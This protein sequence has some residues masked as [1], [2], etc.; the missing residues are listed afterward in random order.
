[1]ATLIVN[2]VVKNSPIKGWGG[3]SKNV[4]KMSIIE[5][6]QSGQ[7]LFD[8]SDLTWAHPLTHPST[9]R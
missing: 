8:F 3:L 9:H 7:D 6:S 2:F 5:I 4:Q 1:M